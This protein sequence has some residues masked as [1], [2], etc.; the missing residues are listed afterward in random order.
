[1]TD[2]RV[3]CV[4]CR[5]PAPRCVCGLAGTIHN[6]TGI[7][8][9]QHPGE[10]R[11]AFNTARLARDTLADAA[12]H[13]VWPD[14]DGALRFTGAIPDGAALLYPRHDAV[15]LATVPP[16]A[17]PRHLVVIDG[18]WAQARTVYRDNP[19]LEG[20]PHVQ[21]TGVA[22]SRYRIRREP[23]PHF[24]STIESIAVALELI[25]PDTAGLDH[26]L[27]GFLAMVDTQADQSIERVRRRKVR[28]RPSVTERIATAWDQLVVGYAEAG[29][30]RRPGRTL[31][32]F[33]AVRP[34]TG[35][36]FEGAV[37]PADPGRFAAAW[38]AFAGP[39]PVVACWSPRAVPLL[40]AA[41][42][43]PTDGI[44]LRALYGNVRAGVSG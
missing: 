14:R 15:E 2:P 29:G 34:S 24:L 43:V 9:L 37:D 16:E 11:H 7:T 40:V 13:V 23:A 12:L 38:A 33:A 36:G 39:H 3:T 31:A 6:R 22:P 10:R 28:Q 20:L 17:R 35:E 30:R 21:L 19:W 8:I 1:M 44:C 41:T 42:G 25:E 32:R 27:D 4:R 26:L 5:R 18:T